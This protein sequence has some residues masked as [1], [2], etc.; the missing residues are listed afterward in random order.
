MADNIHLFISAP[1]NI[2]PTNI[3]KILKSINANGMFKE[4]PNLN[5]SKFWR[6]ALWSKVY[7]LGTAEAVSSEIIVNYI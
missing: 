1:P 2:D 5:K 7:Y 6:S 3:V 4:F